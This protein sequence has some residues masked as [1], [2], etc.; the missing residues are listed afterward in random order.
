MKPYYKWHDRDDFSLRLLNMKTA[1]EEYLLKGEARTTFISDVKKALAALHSMVADGDG[2]VIFCVVPRSKNTCPK[3]WLLEAVVDPLHLV[4]LQR[5]ESVEQ[6]SR[7]KDRHAA[8][9]TIKESD[10]KKVEEATTVVFVDDIFTTGNT[11]AGCRSMLKEI[12][13]DKPI[14]YFAV[15]RTQ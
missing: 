12:Y 2:I 14:V 8:T 6:K 7:D 10:Q 4:E 15:A 3:P 13:P 9:I 5:T 11:M 1:K